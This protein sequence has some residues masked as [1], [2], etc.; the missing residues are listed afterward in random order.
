MEQSS[1]LHS[2]YRGLLA[3]HIVAQELLSHRASLLHK[4]SFWVRE[5][6]QSG[7]EVDFVVQHRG[8]VVPVEVKAGST[9]RMRSLHQFVDAAGPSY[10]VR[11]YAGPLE[12][13]NCRTPGGT[14]FEL[15]S[16]PYCLTPKLPEYL[17][18]LSE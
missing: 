17:D 16:L 13:Q 14:P 3:E 2:F 12:R 4:P 9:G 15:L 6:S 8:Q 7:A 5:K 10:A 11:L 1:D 18:W